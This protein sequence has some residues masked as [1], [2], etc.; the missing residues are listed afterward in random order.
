M[1][2]VHEDVKG[3]SINVT[4]QNGAKVM[5]KFIISEIEGNPSAIIFNGINAGGVPR[6]GDPHPD[7]PFQ[8]VESIQSDVLG[9]NEIALSINYSNIA[10]AVDEEAQVF[11]SISGSVQ[12]VLTNEFFTPVGKQLMQLDY[13]YPLNRDPEGTNTVKKI[14]ATANKQ[15]AI[16]VV[17]LKRLES[18]NP[19]TKAVR[20]VDRIN[21]RRFL[22][23]GPRTWLCS[24]ITGDSNDGNE[25]YQVSYV[26]EFRPQTWDVDLF[27]TN[28]ETG[29]IPIDVKDQPLAFNNFQI[30]EAVDF[31]ALNLELFE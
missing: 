3:G 23:T 7:I 11:I 8:T 17:T 5:R 26:F 20:F 18:E 31:G 13:R 9:S 12:S 14:I 22:G 21:T 19:L 27:F 24:S 2:K 6:P 30:Q 1:T 16:I 28:K 10:Q 29:E 25:T 4:L 15:Q